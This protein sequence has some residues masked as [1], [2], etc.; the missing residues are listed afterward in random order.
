MKSAKDDWLASQDRISVWWDE[1]I[2]EDENSFCLVLDLHESYERSCSLE[3]R[4][5][6]PK[7]S[8]ISWRR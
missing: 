8:D 7:R 6:E 1:Y 2:V 3:D 4:I 5:S